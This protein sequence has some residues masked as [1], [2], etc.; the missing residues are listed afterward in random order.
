[1][2]CTE[3]EIPEI[4]HLL[5]IEGDTYTALFHKEGGGIASLFDREGKDW[6]G[7]S[8]L[9]GSTG[10]YRGIPNLGPVFHPGYTNSIT[11][12]AKNDEERVELLVDSKDGGWRA[13][14]FFLSNRIEMELEKAA[15]P[16]WFLYEGTPGGHF[17]PQSAHWISSDGIERPQSEDWVGE[18]PKPGWVAFSS[19]QAGRSLYIRN[20]LTGPAMDQYWPMEGNMTVFGYGREYKCCSRYLKETPARFS[21]GFLESIDPKKIAGE[22]SDD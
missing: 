17:S 9:P 2:V 18:L 13:R 7:F 12:L 3:N 5:R 21:L 10:E 16:Y 19:P 8:R 14:W 20:Y 6:I 4:G 1:M 15:E 22:L 11:I